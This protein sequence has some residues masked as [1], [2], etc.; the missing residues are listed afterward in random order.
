MYSLLK[1]CFFYNVLN[2]KLVDFERFQ[3]GTPALE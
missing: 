3:K 1:T 2:N